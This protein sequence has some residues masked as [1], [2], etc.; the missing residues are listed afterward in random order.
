[1]GD[2]AALA[3]AVIDLLGETARADGAARAA[4]AARARAAFRFDRYAIAL[5]RLARPA[6]TPISVVVPAY[7]YARFMERRLASVFAQTYPVAEVIVLDDASTDDSVAVARRTAEDW[8]RDIR[9]VVN[10]TNSGSAF[11]QWRRA[12]GM[13]EGEWLW[14]AEADDEAEPGLLA[15]LAALVQER[16][17]PRAG[18]LRQPLHRRRR[19]ADLA[20][21]PGLLCAPAAPP[22]WPSGGVFPAREFARRFLAERNLILNVS[23]VLWRRTSLLAALDRCGADLDRYR[24]AGDWRL[25]LE[26]AGRQH[27]PGG[28]GGRAAQRA[29]PPCRQRHRLAGPRRGMSTR[30]RG[31]TRWRGPARP[32]AR[33]RA[34]PGRLPPPP[35]RAIS[36]PRPRRRETPASAAGRGRLPHRRR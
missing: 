23:A 22:R 19:P 3:D 1:M 18:V 6:L 24:L 36:A 7:N 29:P 35:G 5:L 2:A 13:A 15:G 34:P 25:Y 16:A 10:A 30:S 14:I 9:L 4:L 21:L 33:G 20:E 27:G 12:A 17:G 8:G 31:C 32:A 11:R 26:A 28:R